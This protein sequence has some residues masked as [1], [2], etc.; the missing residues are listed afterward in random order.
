MSGP[1]SVRLV[2]AADLDYIDIIRRSA[3]D[4]GAMQA[5]AYA[6]TL[7]LAIEALGADGTEAIGVKA[8]EEIGPGIFTLHVARFGRRAAHLLVFQVDGS[9]I[10]VLRILHEKMDLARHV[11]LPNEPPRQ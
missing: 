4:F 7:D 11:S 8:R 2:D 9:I 10:E 1:L 6:E 3:R 5:E